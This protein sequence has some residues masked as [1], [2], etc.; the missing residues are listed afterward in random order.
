MRILVTGGAGYIGSHVVYEY[1]DQGHSVTIFDDLSLGLD[2]TIKLGLEE[3]GDPVAV[4]ESLR[5]TLSI[6]GIQINKPSEPIGDIRQLTGKELQWR[7]EN[8]PC[9]NPYHYYQTGTKHCQEC[10][11]CG[12]GKGDGHQCTCRECLTEYSG[13]NCPHCER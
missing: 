4:W 6:I 2:M 11:Q 12:K 1:I 10:G 5:N 8:W 13:A 3:M 7:Y 9:S